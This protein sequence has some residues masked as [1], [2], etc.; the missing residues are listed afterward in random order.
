MASPPDAPADP[1]DSPTGRPTAR[2]GDR[3]VDGRNN[4]TGVRRSSTSVAADLPAP[5]PLPAG[6]AVHEFVIESTLGEGGFGIVYLAHDQLLQRQVALKEYMPGSLAVR[7]AD[8][9]VTLRSER[10]R[11]SFDLGLRSF[12]NEARLLASFD[13]PSLV[14]VYRFWEELGTAYMVMPYYQGPTL[15]AWQHQQRVTD[16]PGATEDWWH[17]RLPALIDALQLMHD[18]QCFHRDIA[19]DNI[20]LVGPRLW[21]VLLDFGAARKVLTDATQALT[22]ILKPGYAPIEQY[23]EVPSLKQGAW[24]DVYALCA[25]LYNSVTGST[26]PPAV[27]RMVSDAWQPAAERA[28]GRFSDQFLRGIDAGL[29]VLP[30]DRPQSLTELRALLGLSPA[31]PDPLRTQSAPTMRAAAPATPAAAPTEAQRRPTTESRPPADPAAGAGAGPGYTVT[32]RDQAHQ[33]GHD[34]AADGGDTVPIDLFD[35][36]TAIG[37]ANPLDTSPPPGGSSISRPVGAAGPATGGQAPRTTQPPPPQPFGAS[38]SAT[39]TT[40][41]P[42]GRPGVGATPFGAATTAPQP[43]G[44]ASAR[45]TPIHP[46]ASG[47]IGL[48][49]KTSRT[50]V[51]A[52]GVGLAIAAAAV[53]WWGLR[54]PSPEA[55]AA[56]NTTTS[57]PGQTTQ[58]QATPAPVS[59]SAVVPTTTAAPPASP[60]STTT[61]PRPDYSPVAALRDMVALADPAIKVS[62]STDSPR[63]RIDQDKLQFRV[64][65]NT[66]GFVYVFWVGSDGKDLQLL[67][68]NGLDDDHAIAAG[69]ELVLP[70]P[71]WRITASGPP[72]TDHI[73]VLVSPVQRDLESAGAKA[74][75]GEVLG[76]F[77]ATLARKLWKE[78]DGKSSPFAGIARC[79]R[80]QPCN[81]GYGGAL[82]EVEEVR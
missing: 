71:G 41:P 6:Y 28:A 40:Q 79:V 44:T 26:P 65:S 45:V 75:S 50:P 30:K 37:Q 63:L 33:D 73:A 68:P 23:A 81:A 51:I 19:P 31:V 36:P 58:T 72:G 70:R 35:L 24:T 80:T 74:T 78:S 53:L 61:A 3:T 54:P 20:L 27:A 11:E 34:N 48:P 4:A 60:G 8:Y 69:A 12:I 10:H 29:A 49:G 64:R 76:T 82:V 66:P 2:T 13:H 21:P 7:R 56:S 77:D 9:G 46:M 59:P 22:V 52:A 55:T 32:Q 43:G 47:Q 1:P 67:F 16:S 25:V 14:K 57:T 18:Q 42:G 17:E 62:A 38:S 5:G 15:K 39:P